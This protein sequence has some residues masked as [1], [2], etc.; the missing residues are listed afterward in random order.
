LGRVSKGE[1]CS[2][3]GCGKNAVRSISV[4]DAKTAGLEVEGRRAYLCEEHYKVV[5]KSRKKDKQ[6]QK[7]RYG[8]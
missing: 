1:K 6:L 5:K 4:S 3:A 8:I 2:V 7:W